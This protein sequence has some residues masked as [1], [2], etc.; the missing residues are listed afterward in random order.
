MTPQDEE[1]RIKLETAVDALKALSPRDRVSV[2]SDVF[3][4]DDTIEYVGRSGIDSWMIQP[5][6]HGE[7]PMWVTIQEEGI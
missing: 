7:D 4:E 3:N 2:I 5:E 6:G 1:Y